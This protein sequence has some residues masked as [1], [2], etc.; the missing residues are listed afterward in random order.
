MSIPRRCTRRRRALGP[1]HVSPRALTCMTMFSGDTLVL[2]YQAVASTACD[3]TCMQRH[4][5]GLR[6]A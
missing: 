4:H 5:Q 3:T 1:G 6:F 2:R